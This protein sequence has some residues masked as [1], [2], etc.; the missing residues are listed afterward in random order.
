MTGLEVADL[1]VRV[2]TTTLIS[3]AGFGAPAG[4]LTALLG[5]NGAGKSTL[6]RTLAGADRPAAGSIRFEDVDL[7]ALS[8]RDRARRVAF[9]EQDAAT[10]LA[11][12]VRDVVGLGRTPHESILGGR[13]ATGDAAVNDALARTGADAFADRELPTLSGGERQRVMLARA[14][15]QDPR[16]LLLDEP[17]NHLDIAAQL[18]TLD[19][20]DALAASGVTVLVALHD[21]ALAAAHAHHVVVLD[22]GRVVAEGEPEP[23]LTPALIRSVYRVDAR[24]IPDPVTG[25]NLLALARRGSAPEERDDGVH[26]REHTDPPE[27][28]A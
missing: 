27:R 9:V 10:E 13:D 16:L 24:W 1:T 2:G 15:A 28:D 25:K 17:T 21:L 22:H 4:S 12:S 5:P 18:D 26:Q 19:L 6:L 11:L 8:R 3:D 14:L 23:T 20:I 7:L